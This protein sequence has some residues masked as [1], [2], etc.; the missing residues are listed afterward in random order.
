MPANSAPVKAFFPGLPSVSVLTSERQLSLFL[1]LQTTNDIMRAQ[2][3]DLKPNPNYFQ[4]ASSPYAIPLGVRA[5]VHELIGAGA[6]DTIQ[7]PVQNCSPLL[8]NKLPT[9]SGL[10]LQKFISHIYKIQ[11]EVGCGSCRC[12]G[13]E[14]SLTADSQGH[15]RT[16]H[17]VSRK[18]KRSGSYMG[19]FSR[20][21][22]EIIHLNSTQIPLGHVALPTCRRDGE[23]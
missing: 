10:I 21:V 23:L 6:G 19:G 14:P 2:P 8:H 20:P 7:C 12:L 4:R 1:F 3:H 9:F 15:L 16:H 17:S 11:L 18:E 13:S 5:S 22:L